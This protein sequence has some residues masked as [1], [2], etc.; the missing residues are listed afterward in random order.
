MNRLFSLLGVILTALAAC[1]AANAQQQQS[2]HMGYVFPAGGRQ[3]TQFEVRAGGQYLV[4]ATNG[5]VSGSG[6]QVK[7]VEVVKPMTQQEAN[8]LREQLKALTARIPAGAAQ[9]EAGRSSRQ[10]GPQDR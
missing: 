6:V 7:V 10:D 5:Y 1:A 9:R 3:G 2:P 8:A 4:G